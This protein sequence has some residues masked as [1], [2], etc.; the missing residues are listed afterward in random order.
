MRRL[1]LFSLVVLAACSAAETSTI[2]GI[3]T[4]V[5]GD[6]TT[7]ESFDVLT[8]E[9][10]TIRLVPAPFG[11]FDFPLPHLSSH[12][13]FLE[14]VRVTYQVTDDGVNLAAKISD[15]PIGGSP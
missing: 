11:N 1:A 13:R 14:P 6:L 3:V 8:T 7:V 10:E 9:G 12:M 2:D 4:A 5:N 15:A